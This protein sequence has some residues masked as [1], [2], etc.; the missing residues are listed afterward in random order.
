M[1]V[2]GFMVVMGWGMW[3][4]VCEEGDSVVVETGQQVSLPPPEAPLLAFTVQSHHKQSCAAL[5]EKLKC[6]AGTDSQAP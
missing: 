4:G 2:S 1:M 6:Q 5:E 3:W